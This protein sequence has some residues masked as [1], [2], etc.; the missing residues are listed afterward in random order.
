[1]S[2]L[3]P[4]SGNPEPVLRRSI[5]PFQLTLYGLGSMLGSGIYGL[6]GQAAGLAGNA[7]WLAFLV[8]MVAALLTALSYASLGSR[9]PRAGG[10]AFVTERAYGMPL[11]S[12][13]VGLAVVASGLTSIAT[14]SQV[15]AVNLASIAGLAALPAWTIAIGFLMVLTGLVV[16][17]IRE[18]MW[19]NVV[20]TVIEAGGLLLVIAVGIPYWGSVDLLQTPGSPNGD[21]LIVLVFQGAVLTFFAFI[22]FEDILNVAEECRDP[23]RTI[24]VALVTAMVVGASIYVAVAVSSVS[25]VPWQELAAAPG[26]LT[27]VMRR[28]APSIPV[29]VFAGITLFAVANTALVNYVTSSRMV[30]GMARQGLLPAA[31]GRIGARTRTPGLAILVLF[32]LLVPLAFFGSI[33]EL[34]SASVLMLLVV[35]AVVNGAL[36]ILQGRVGEPKGGFEVPRFV[37]ALGTVICLVLIAVRLAGG[38]WKAPALAGGLLAGMIAFHVVRTRIA[39]C[40]A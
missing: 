37:P 6:I 20:C 9:Y 2:D 1:M 31:M 33:A 30:Y 29:A 21:V 38:D 19:V 11:L 24:P 13:V 27:E 28:A 18:S 17:G 3:R 16:R 39:R 5:G 40:A 35:F 8:A 34:A 10:A 26:P 7:V 14:Q 22:G 23:Q 15:F 4:G 32:L 36:L 12:F 25:V